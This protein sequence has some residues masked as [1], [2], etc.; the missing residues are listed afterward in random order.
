MSAKEKK[1]AGSKKEDGGG[2]DGG[3]G[4]G[5]DTPRKGGRKDALKAVSRFFAKAPA[6]G[7]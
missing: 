7:A 6:K 1:A 2:S 3:T 5:T 4:T